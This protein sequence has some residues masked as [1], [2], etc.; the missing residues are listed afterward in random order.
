LDQNRI[1]LLKTPTDTKSNNKRKLPLVLI[2]LAVVVLAGLS[3]LVVRNYQT[4]NYAEEVASPLEKSLAKADGVKKCSR[5]DAGRGSDNQQPWYESYFA[6]PGGK[7]EATAA[8]N[9]AAN[10]AGYQPVSASSSNKGHLS[11]ISDAYIQDWSFDDASKPSPYKDLADGPVKLAFGVNASGAK[12]AC[13]KDT[14][15]VVDDAHSVVNIRV[16]LPEFKR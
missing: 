6:V 13:G 2:A 8:I 5:G 9:S 14:S 10:E 1:L 3:W 7:A 11:F 16:Q 15:N 4:K 12:E